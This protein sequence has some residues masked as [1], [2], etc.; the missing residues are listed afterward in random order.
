MIF[1]SG[2]SGNVV[3]GNYVGTDA[4]GT[5]K[6]GNADAG[7]LLNAG[8]TANAVG[9]TTASARNIISG[10][11]TYGVQIT[12]SGTSGNLIEGDYVGTDATGSAALPNHVGIQIDTAAVSNTIGGLTATPGAG[13]GNVISGNAGDGVNLT[14]SAAQPTAS[15]VIEGN[16]I[17]LNA[18]GSASI[19]N[20]V[21]VYDSGAQGN[22]IGGTAAGAGNVISGNG[23]LTNGANVEFAGGAESSGN[24]VAGN[25]IGTDI[26]GN[27]S[28]GSNY[29]GILLM[30]GSV[31]N[32]IGGTSALARNVIGG[33]SNAGVEISGAGTIT[34]FVEGNYVGTNAAGSAAVANA[35]GVLF[36]SGA[37]SNTVGGGAAGDRNVI[38]GNSGDGV[39]MTGSGTSGNL[40]QGN[41]IGTDSTGSAAL[42]NVNDGIGIA[43]GAAGNTIGG[44]ASGAGN[45]ISGNSARGVYI[46]DPGTNNN[47][48]LGTYVGTDSTGSSLISNGNLGV[49]LNNGA[50]ANTVGG[51]T[52]VARNVIDSNYA[53]VLLQAAV[54]STVEGNYI[55][56]NANGSA[57]LSGGS[58]Y[59]VFSS[60]SGNVIG[61]TT[62]TPGTGAGN[63]IA[64]NSY[65]VWLRYSDANND[66]VQGNILGLDA[67]GSTAQGAVG[68]AGVW[69]SDGASG[70]TIGG[71]TT[72]ARNIIAN[73]SDG[74][75][76]SG[77]P[78]DLTTGN[79]IEGN[80]IGTDITGG[81]ARSN[82][83]GIYLTSYSQGNMAIGNVISG[84]TA[85]G[86]Y[87][88]A[89][90]NGNLLRGNFIGTNAAGTATLAN[91]GNGITINASSGNTI[92]GTTA[93]ARNVISGNT[94]EGVQITGAGATGNAIEGNFV[95]TDATGTTALPNGRV[96]ASNYT[97][98]G[99]DDSGT[100]NTIGG[101]ASAARNIISGNV[102]DGVEIEGGA[103]GTLV[104]GNYIGTDL[105]GTKA[106]S[107]TYDVG[108]SG[109]GDFILDNLIDAGAFGLALNTINS[110]LP[111]ILVQGNS[112]GVDVTGEAAIPN[113]IGIYVTGPNSTIGGTTAAARNVISGNQGELWYYGSNATGNLLQGNYIGTDATGAHLLINTSIGV[114]LENGPSGNTVGGTAAGAGNVIVGNIGLTQFD[115]FENEGVIIEG[116]SA[117]VPTSGNLVEGNRIGTDVT[118]S[119]ALANNIGVEIIGAGADGNTV[120]GTA[121]GAR[122]LISG[123]TEDGIVISGT[124][125]NVVAGNY[126]GIDATGT[127]AVP[128]GG[129]GVNIAAGGGSNTI[130]GAVA[131]AGNVIS[132]NSGYGVFDAGSHDAIQGNLIGLNAAGT[133]ALGDAQAAILLEG[134]HDLVGGTTAAAR[135]VMAGSAGNMYVAGSQFSTIEGNYFGINAAGT[136]PLGDSNIDLIIDDGAGNDMFGGQAAGMGNVFGGSQILIDIGDAGS[137]IGTDNLVIQGNY[138]GTDPTLTRNLGGGI[139][140][141]LA[142][143]DPA[144][145][146]HNILIGGG[147]A[148]DGNVL[149]NLGGTGIIVAGAGTNG[150]QV[151]GNTILNNKGDGILINAAAASNTVGGTAAGDRNVISG[152]TNDGIDI[153]DSDTS[154]NVVEGNYI[155]TD[156]TGAAALPNDVEGVFVKSGAGGN[157]IGGTVAGAGNVISG[158]GENGVFVL[159]SSGTLIEGN[160]IGTNAT[161]SAA[162]GNANDGVQ[163]QSSS[164]DTV[165]GTS[166][167]AR[168]VISANGQFN[169]YLV[170]A[171]NETVDGN[172]IGTD[173]AG[174]LA[175]G[176]HIFAGVEILSSSNNLIGGTAAG[177]GNVIS[178]AGIGID[179]GDYNAV[180]ATT[181]VGNVFQGNLIGLNAAGTAAVPNLVA[182]IVVEYAE[183]TQI[184]GTAL[185]ANN[186]ISGSGGAGNT[187][188]NDYPTGS[189]GSGIF[190]FGPAP[191][192]LIQGNRIGTDETGTSAVPNQ[193]SGV[194]LWNSTATISGNQI[195]GNTD[196]GVTVLGDG[197]PNGLSGLWPAD[198][199]TND[200]FGFDGTL[201]G[202][203]TYAPG[204][205]GQAFSFDGVSGAFQDNTAFSPP[206]SRIQYTSG[207]SMEAWIKTTSANGT[208]ITDGGGIDTQIGMGLFLKNGQLEAIGSKGTAGQFNFQLT[209]PGTI[210]D[211]QWHLVAVTW[212]GTSAA[213]GV[214]LYIDG[215]RVATGTALASIT[216]ASSPLYFGGDPN[217]ALP[218]YQGLLDEVSVYSLPLSAGTIATSYS[219]RGVALTSNATAITGNFVGTNSAGTAALANG[220]SGVNIE[221]SSFDTVVGTT[222]TACNVIS[223]NTN[224][225]VV[226]SGSGTTGNLVAGNYIG[227][228]VTGS[229]TLA[230]G[231]NGVEI[232]GAP[233][234]TVGGVAA[235]AQ[236]PLLSS[237]GLANPL[238]LVRTSTGALYFDDQA[239]NI[240]YRLDPISGALTVFSSGGLL[241]AAEALAYDPADNALV[242]SNYDNNINSGNLIRIDLATG[243][244]T[245]VTSGQLLKDPD[246]I[247]VAPNG[248]YLVSNFDYTTESNQIVQVNPGTSAQTPLGGSIAGQVNDIAVSSTGQIYVS[249]LVSGSP[250]V[251]AILGVDPVSGSTTVISS[252]GNLAFAGGLTVLSDGSIV[253][254]VQVPP[255]GDGPS[256]SQLVKVDPKTGSQTVISSG[257]NLIDTVDVAAEPDGDLLAVNGL[258][259]PTQYAVVRVQVNPARNVI[260][261]N[262]DDGVLISGSSGNVVAGNFIGT[263]AAGTAA[264]GNSVDGVDVDDGAVNNTVGGTSTGA[265]N[266]VSGSNR[267]GVEFA[268]AGSGNVALGNMIGTDA[269]GTTALGNGWGVSVGFDAGE[270]IGGTTAGAR[271]LISGN[272]GGINIDVTFGLVI[273]GNW[274]GLNAA[275]TAAVPNLSFGIQAAG[276]GDAENVVIGGTTPGAGNVISGNGGVGIISATQTTSNFLIQGNLIG[277]NPSGASALDLG[278]QVGVQIL[279]G[280]TTIGG[281]TAAARNIISGNNY[282]VQISNATATGDAVE[283]NYIGTDVT[284]T[285]SLNNGGGPGVVVQEGANNNTIGGT[286]SGAGNLISGNNIGVWLIYGGTT[287]NVVEGNFVGTNAGGT[288]S[289]GNVTGVEISNGAS[290]NTVGGSTGGAAN[291]IS[292]NANG[293]VYLTGS[294]TSGNLLEGNFVGTNVS[295][296]NLGNHGAGV[297]LDQGAADNSVGGPTAGMGN[298]IAFNTEAG[299]ALTGSATTGDTI[300][301]NSIYGNAQLG[302]DLG[303]TG[304]VLANDSQ[305]HVGPNNNQDYPVLQSFTPGLPTVVTGTYG[306]SAGAQ[307]TLDLYANPAADPSGFGQGQIYLGSQV[308]TTGAN[309]AFTATVDGASLPSYVLSATATDPGDTSEFSRD[310]TFS[311]YDDTP[312]QVA[313]S[314]PATALAG[315]G[316]P[317]SSIITGSTTGKTYTYAWSVTQPANPAFTLPAGSVRTQPNLIFTPPTPGTYVAALTVMDNFGATGS[318]VPFSIIVGVPG[319]GVVIKGLAQSDSYAAGTQVSLTSVV[320]E[321]TGATPTSYAWV[322]TLNGGPFTLPSGTVTNAPAF[323][324]TPAVN[325]LYGVSLNVVDSN[326]GTAGTSVF[327]V[328]TGARRRR[329]SS[330]RRRPARRGRRSSSAPPSIRG[331]PVRCSSTGPSSSTATARPT[332]SRTTTPPASCRSRRTSRA[333]TRSPSASATGSTA[334]TRPPSPSRSTPCRP[335]P[336]SPVTRPAPRPAR[337]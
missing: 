326:G 6:R 69:I 230:N 233:A 43:N 56:I 153:S 78:S 65:N 61:G 22:T 131:G 94:N 60:G 225:G 202:G 188:G 213:G 115:S 297:L 79:V 116:A 122:N 10:N 217:L 192:T 295:G 48:V 316:V 99:I 143:A 245:L 103:S 170:G 300:R 221:S 252:G 63:V 266:V 72:G 310:L 138:L 101:P 335:R 183:N 87:I 163:L 280:G 246:G 86:V 127:G 302:I 76:V 96:V 337:R 261:G 125:G 274:I 37:A 298:T 227:T 27:S 247:A 180:D 193:G 93:G 182:G 9:G 204:I 201:L 294:G 283:G 325:G 320:S 222:A 218:Y 144:Q 179:I 184:G 77:G 273:E 150:V 147:T 332:S 8:A 262:T 212:T 119:T 296:A 118:G 53:N 71:T 215:V 281:T 232:N 12:G 331:C 113:H 35:T 51:T 314:G 306:S 17:G 114:L 270:T 132:G 308:V 199:S 105:T 200:G 185:G 160:W 157:T 38:S 301:G 42:S 333:P 20:A 4:S 107:N 83:D 117:L 203:A 137:P 162:L 323:N 278:S 208:L 57:V 158:N 282:N 168:N 67:T 181:T 259:H 136:A 205:S 21:G 322:V 121:V 2:A 11:T 173:V 228:D 224:D 206:P 89:S 164:N 257:G 154:G 40:V 28:L 334:A 169:V 236:Q 148:G 311:P 265:G 187:F 64:G 210:D 46:S 226:I 223:G 249:D 84:N 242:V 191:G 50:S 167:A 85:T 7:V 328:V 68:G 211:G 104:Q 129:D 3:L 267:A 194:F 214:V 90:A 279:V 319:P 268:N 123:N 23:G 309:G 54:N 110:S 133:A 88:D 44:T 288:A 174:S 81:L 312:P 45:V 260:S 47:L 41:Y 178:G 238:F 111:G 149:T 239:A 24:L 220:G 26:T 293:G 304:G 139:G 229:T 25:F 34:N 176:P 31:F 305:G 49:M 318:A 80:Y 248:T 82:T 290:G 130:G 237:A 195:S 39:Q 92:G 106:L 74:I 166:A 275:G 329:A 186:I 62:A 234:N 97:G 33:N 32:T 292:A 269:S 291:V 13:D 59:G 190:L 299:V 70:N 73:C 197:V 209:G 255:A 271:N 109:N 55:G 146:V 120:G 250:F 102:N 235:P 98:G 196:D 141:S 243:N 91:G 216:G 5:A 108:E 124:S 189:L 161:G 52:A 258:F 307:F 140:I 16:Y 251:S 1:G 276:P 277:T 14:G 29:D 286:A 324:F 145:G 207:A 285:L 272:F 135:N 175:L 152:N 151:Q 159:Q 313:I 171:T 15:N 142:S 128:D 303:N 19:P 172:Y 165:G 126:I 95:G 219:L 177:A 244:Q 263:N 317:L 30:G 18:A 156:S 100:N 254:A 155:G 253:T 264:L 134:D 58:L 240:I 36:D 198:N 336:I 66:A 287:G 330:G 241:T 321:P 315:I 75:D 327:F 256:P 231:N 112:I 284:G 289:V